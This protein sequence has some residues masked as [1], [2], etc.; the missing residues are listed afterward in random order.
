MELCVTEEL[1]RTVAVCS[2]TPGT[3]NEKRDTECHWQRS[4]IAG[5]THWIANP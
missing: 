1:C 5:S 3:S 4:M 2:E